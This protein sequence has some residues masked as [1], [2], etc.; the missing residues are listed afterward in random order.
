MFTSRCIHQNLQNLSKLVLDIAFGNPIVIV[1]NE[2]QLISMSFHGY[3]FMCYIYI[4][5][6]TPT[7]M[8]ANYNHFGFHG[9]CIST[10]NDGL[11]PRPSLGSPGKYEFKSPKGCLSLKV[12]LKCVTF[13]TLDFRCT[14]DLLSTQS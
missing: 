4:Y 12:V 2:L 11:H 7:N 10:Y 3:M 5:I 13:P 6:Y 1:P 14:Y 9:I 8:H